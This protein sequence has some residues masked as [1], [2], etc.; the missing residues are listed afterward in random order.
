MKVKR[1]ATCAALLTISVALLAQSPAFE[2][3]SIR[4]RVGE[5]Q[6]PPSSPTRFANADATLAFL[7]SFAY[8]VKEFQI[9]G[10][11]SWIR[12]DR[13]EVLATTYEPTSDDRMRLM[14]QRLLADRFGLAVHRDTTLRDVYALRVRKEAAARMKRSSLD[15]VAQ[16]TAGGAATTADMPM[17]CAWRMGISGSLATLVMDGAPLSQL[18]DLLERFVNRRVIDETNLRG[19]YDLRLTFAADQVTWRLPPDA[20][21]G[22]ISGDEVALDTALREQLSL[23]LVSTRGSVPIV[24]IDGVQRPE[25]N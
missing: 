24:V 13:F 4:P 11:P 2:A 21:P 23:Q 17:P 3:A 1:I 19:S 16:R 20:Q 18:A 7:V 6:G 25:P 12:S 5:A 22:A 8:R 9:V 14:M 10:G 15:C